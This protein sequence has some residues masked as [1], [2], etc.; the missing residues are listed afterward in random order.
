M[1]SEDIIKWIMAEHH[2]GTKAVES[3]LAAKQQMCSK[4]KSKYCTNFKRTNHTANECWEEGG[5]NH[6]NALA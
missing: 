6:A 4:G 2:E 5:G 1:T 3:T